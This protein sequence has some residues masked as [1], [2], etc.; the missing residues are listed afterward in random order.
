[1]LLLYRT[2]KLVE[3][4]KRLEPYVDC[5]SLMKTARSGIFGEYLADYVR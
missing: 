1:M 5:S 3:R 2:V 4:L